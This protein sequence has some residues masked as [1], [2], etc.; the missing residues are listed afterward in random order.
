MADLAHSNPHSSHR[1]DPNFLAVVVM[2][3]V[4]LLLAFAAALLIVWLA[5]RH[6][7][8]AKPN[9]PPA[10]YLTVPAQPPVAGQAAVAAS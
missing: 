2:S 3:G 9:Y 7:V 8:P 4:A 1:E 10:V 6:L 5:G